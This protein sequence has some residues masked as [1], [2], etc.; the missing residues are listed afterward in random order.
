LLNIGCRGVVTVQLG[1][2]NLEW[3]KTQTCCY[4]TFE[5]ARDKA[6]E[7]NDDKKCCPK[8]GQN[9]AGGEPSAKIVWVQFSNESGVDL[10]PDPK[11]GCID[12]SR[13]I[14][15]IDSP[16]GP[17]GAN[18]D[19]KIW[20]ED[21]EHWLGAN[22]GGTVG[23]KISTCKDLD[24]DIKKGEEAGLELNFYCPTC[25]NTLPVNPKK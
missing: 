23:T 2:F 8:A 25:E 5:R 6:K 16:V 13:V 10:K 17:G 9:W 15:E 1:Y 22:F 18:F 3:L 24:D 20:L 11:T 19:Y 14:D 7:M 21:F 12:L 4:S